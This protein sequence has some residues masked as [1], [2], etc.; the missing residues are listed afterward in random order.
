MLPLL[1]ITTALY[2]MG[3]QAWAASAADDA[4]TLVARVLA[5]NAP[6]LNPTPMTGTYNLLREPDGQPDVITGP[7]SFSDVASNGWQFCQPYRVGSMVWTPLHC[8][9]AGDSPYTV[10][11]AGQTNWNGLN[12]EAVDVQFATNVACCIGMGGQGDVSYSYCS[13]HQIQSAYL[14]IE[15][16]NAVPV[17]MVTYTSPTNRF[18]YSPTWQ[19]DLPFYSITDAPVPQTAGE[20]SALPF[21]GIDGGLAPHH[22]VW[23]EPSTFKESQVFQV[24]GNLWFFSQGDSRWGTNSFGFEGHIQT[25]LMTNV[26]IAPPTPMRVKNEEAR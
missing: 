23:N 21:N 17:Y 14:L 12:L 5:T 25:V 18:Q 9:A 19:F 2:L 10:T 7:F 11:G 26:N 6:W 13:Y 22:L 1:A 16:T 15:P 24:D 4:G 3:E 8:M 20:Q